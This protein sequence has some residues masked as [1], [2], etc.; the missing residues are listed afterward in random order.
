[1]KL[2]KRKVFSFIGVGT[3]GARSN[4]SRGRGRQ[5]ALTEIVNFSTRRILQQ[6]FCYSLPFWLI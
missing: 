3:M 1:M 2:T 5:T 4:F 6:K